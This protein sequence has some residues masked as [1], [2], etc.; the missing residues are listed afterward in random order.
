[1]AKPDSDIFEY[2]LKSLGVSAEEAMFIDDREINIEGALR[3]GIS[4]IFA[5][6]PEELRSMLEAIGFRP[7]PPEQEASRA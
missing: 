3:A 2:C 7:L 5:P 4:G 1:M 6:S